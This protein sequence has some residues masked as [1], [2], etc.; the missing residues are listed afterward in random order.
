M[1]HQH[2]IYVKVCSPAAAVKLLPVMISILEGNF[3]WFMSH[4]SELLPGLCNVLASRISELECLSTDTGQ[5]FRFSDEATGFTV[6][7]AKHS[8]TVLKRVASFRREGGSLAPPVASFLLKV[9]IF[10][11]D[12][13]N[14]FAALPIDA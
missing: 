4:I 6:V 9:W 7:G 3:L 5:Q 2:F 12:I 10:P 11:L 8:N 14:P 1:I 13:A